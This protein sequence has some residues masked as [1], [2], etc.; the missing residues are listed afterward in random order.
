MRLGLLRGRAGEVRLAEVLLISGRPGA[1]KTTLVRR[2]AE[3]FPGRLGGF[4]TEEL[5][6]GGRRVGFALVTL[7]G[8]RAVFAHVAFHAA[9]HRVGRYGVDLDVLERVGVPAVREAASAYRAVVVDEIGK[10]EL[11][12][13]AFREV[14]EEVASGP[15]VLVATILAGGHPW[16]DRFRRRPGVSELRVGPQDREEVF[17]HAR[18]WL[19]ARLP[20]RS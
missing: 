13:R 1:G 20:E 10:M 7:G 18:A 9:S 2:L 14:L 12:S 19:A 15:A 3:A 16:A 6:E 17:L 11:A 4:Y 5:R 8:E